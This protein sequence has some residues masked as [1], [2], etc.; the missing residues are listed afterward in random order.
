MLITNALTRSV[1]TSSGV[2]V[3][4]IFAPTGSFPNANSYLYLNNNNLTS[5]DISN[6]LI[7]LSGS[8]TNWVAPNNIVLFNQAVGA[9][10]TNPSPGYTAYQSLVSS[11]WTVD[12]D[13]C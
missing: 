10:V 9:C 8:A 5:A 1:V 2:N 4:S 13:I 7:Y 3:I 12:V 6:T 11:G